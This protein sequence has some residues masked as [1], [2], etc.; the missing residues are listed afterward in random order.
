MADATSARVLLQAGGYCPI[1]VIGKVPALLAWQKHIETNAAEI[2]LWRKLYP[3]AVNTGILTRLNPTV[4]AD[5]LNEEA[6]EAVEGLFREYLEERGHFLVRMGRAPKRAILLRTDVPFPKMTRNVTAP[7]GS[8]EK[9]EVLCEGQQVVVFGIHPDTKKPYLWHGGEPG[10]IKYEELPYVR[11]EELAELLDQAVALLVRDHGYTTAAERPKAANGAG[12]HSPEDWGYLIRNIVNLTDL[13]DSARDL[14]AKL[15]TA[16]LSAGATVNALRGVF[17]AATVPID[18]SRRR[19]FEERYADIPRAVDGAVRKYGSNVIPLRRE[20]PAPTW[21]LYRLDREPEGGA[22]LTDWLAENMLPKVGVGILSGHPGVGKTHIVN[23]L[24]CSVATGM[25]FAGHEV[26][27]VCGAVL[28]AAE[29]AETAPVRWQVLRHAKTGPWFESNG[30]DPHTPF[31]VDYTDQVPYLNEADAFEQYDAALTGAAKM[32]AERMA[33][34]GVPYDGLGLVCIDTYNAATSLTDD[35]HNRV[36]ST[37]NIFNML[38]KL[39][40]KHQCC[41]VVVDHLGKDQSRG[42]LGSIN[43]TASPD[44]DLRITGTVADDGSVS[45]TAMT[46]HKLRVGAQGRRL[47]FELKTVRVSP[48]QEGKTVRWDASGDGMHVAKQNKRH[49]ALMRALDE[50][51]LEKCQWVRLGDNANYKAADSQLVRRHFELAY[52]ATAAEGEKREKTIRRAFDRAIQ[53]SSKTGLV[54]SKTLTD[55]SVVVWRTDYKFGD[56]YKVSDGGGD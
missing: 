7:N 13:H 9:I 24:M 32:Q 45:H 6:A 38:R 22:V 50:A 17:E 41:I 15:V 34:A 31:P 23:D 35:Q 25:P 48:E 20:Q 54:A 40:V 55:K 47:P 43:K 53:D 8:A 27:R 37:Q 4:D 5:L 26:R 56:S 19:E 49:P 51:I 46:I 30:M 3:D 16:G 21:R 1:P 28:F 11:A 12:A 52:P 33:A 14:A 42:P 10:P 29:G 2:A 18:I 39:A 36:G 44:V